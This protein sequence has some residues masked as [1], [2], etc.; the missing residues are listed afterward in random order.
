MKTEAGAPA[1]LAAVAPVKA[2]KTAVLRHRVRRKIYEAAR[3]LVARL[4]GA[5]TVLVFAKAAAL[6]RPVAEMR[7]DLEALFVKAG[8]LR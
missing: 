8:L 1:K 4:P 6:E 5:C 3:P 7:A 2:A